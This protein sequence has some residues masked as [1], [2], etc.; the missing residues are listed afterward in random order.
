MSDMPKAAR[1][2]DT[3]VDEGWLDAGPVDGEP[4]VLDDDDEGVVDD[5]VD[6]VDDVD[7]VDDAGVFAVVLVAVV[8]AV[9]MMIE[10]LELVVCE[11]LSL[12]CAVKP[13]VVAVVGVPVM[14]PLLPRLSPGGNVPE[15]MVQL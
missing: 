13:D 4:L 1:P 14:L 10:R 9:L 5:D 3:G 8:D 11:A 6:G 2:D 12:I 7:D 15:T